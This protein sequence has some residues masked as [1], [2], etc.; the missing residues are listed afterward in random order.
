[1]KTDWEKF[2]RDL[3]KTIAQFN[4]IENDDGSYR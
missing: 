1:M 2:L 3:T 4:L